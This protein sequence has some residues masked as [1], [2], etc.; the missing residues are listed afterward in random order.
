MLLWTTIKVLTNSCKLDGCC[1]GG[2]AMANISCS[3]MTALSAALPLVAAGLYM[4][5]LFIFF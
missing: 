3:T 4:G 2:D 1:E 5:E